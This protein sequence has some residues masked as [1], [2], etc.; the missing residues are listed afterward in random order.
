MT[1]SLA[2]CLGGHVRGRPGRN[3]CTLRLFSRGEQFSLL[4][5]VL[6]EGY[7]A[8]VEESAEVLSVACE[9]SVSFVEV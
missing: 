2:A 9:V 6:V 7:S 4:A 5:A 1:F 3:A 8:E